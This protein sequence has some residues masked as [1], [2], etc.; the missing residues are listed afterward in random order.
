METSFNKREGECSLFLRRGRT[1]AS[2]LSGSSNSMELGFA[3]V[4]LPTRVPGLC[5]PPLCHLVFSP[6]HTGI[7]DTRKKDTTAWHKHMHACHYKTSSFYVDGCSRTIGQR[8]IV[9]SS[10]RFFPLMQVRGH[11]WPGTG[12]AARTLSSACPCDATQNAPSP[13]ALVRPSNHRIMLS[14]LEN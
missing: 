3:R 10:S 5:V 1:N 2:S 11:L 9:S 8:E 6:F 12:L 13:C 7:E 4:P 14:D